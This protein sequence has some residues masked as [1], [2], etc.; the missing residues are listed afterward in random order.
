MFFIAKNNFQLVSEHVLRKHLRVHKNQN[1]NSIAFK[2]NQ[3]KE[4]KS[5]F[6]F[7][8]TVKSGIL[9]FSR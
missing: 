1:E 7:I 6:N 9:F 3:P 2:E 8:K 4:S 5:I